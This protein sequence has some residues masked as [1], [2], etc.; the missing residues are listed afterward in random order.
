ML[1]NL[2]FTSA[3]NQKPNVDV[4]I[5]KVEFSGLL[6][7]VKQLQ[8]SLGTFGKG[9][10]FDIS[11]DKILVGYQFAVPS[12]NSGAFNLS[13]I[14]LGFDF[15]LYFKNKPIDFW[16]R[17]SEREEPFLLSVGIFGG[18]GYFGIRVSSKQVE[19]VEALLE[20]GGYLGI[21]VG[22]ARGCAFLFVGTF[23]RA[24][25]GCTVELY[26]YLICGGM[27]NI[28]GII[29]MSMTFYMGLSTGG[30]GSNSGTLIG[31]ASVTVKIRLGF[32]KIER[33]ASMTKRITGGSGASVFDSYSGS[34]G[35]RSLTTKL[36]SNAGLADDKF[37]DECDKTQTPIYAADESLLYA[38]LDDR[39]LVNEY[40]NAFN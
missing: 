21:D 35:N 5:S 37:Y 2:Q 18:R 38:S 32:F 27:L 15:N 36:L 29:E 23:Y 6:E 8:E 24:K 9:L 4:A 22:I 39:Y 25:A 20:F 34:S 26:G 19:E 7:L 12:I 16:F 11:A 30:C 13:N 17:F 10:T 3:T 1:R 14:K 28:L 40:S 31:T 33:T